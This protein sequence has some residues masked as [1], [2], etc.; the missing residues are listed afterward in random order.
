[1]IL[2][3]NKTNM[4]PNVLY[5]DNDDDF[6][7]FCMDPTLKTYEYTDA[8]GNVKYKCDYEFSPAYNHAIEQGKVFVILD[9]K[10]RILKNGD[11]TY[12]STT[13]TIDNLDLMY[14]IMNDDY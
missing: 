5:F 10:S 12:R 4:D 11:L 8:E 14:H 7:R 9:P 6:T 13:K 2:I 1:M 3:N